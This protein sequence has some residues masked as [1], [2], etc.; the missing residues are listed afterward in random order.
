[1]FDPLIDLP[2]DGHGIVHGQSGVVAFGRDYRKDPEGK[3][4]RVVVF[5]SGVWMR[6]NAPQ[7]TFTTTSHALVQAL[8]HDPL[9]LE[10]ASACVPCLHADIR[11]T[12]SRFNTGDLYVGLPVSFG[13][14]VC[15]HIIG[16]VDATGGVYLSPE[17]FPIELALLDETVGPATLHNTSLSVSFLINP[18]SV[19]P[20]F[21]ASIV[22]NH[23][24]CVSAHWQNPS[25]ASKECVPD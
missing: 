14:E 25:K 20:I 15:V 2:W 12:C 21:R 22:D 17:P 23:L 10:G 24:P 18:V 16:G 11:L 6:Y 19:A 7:Q 5:L 4:P 13:N 8:L 3:G 1:M 9:F